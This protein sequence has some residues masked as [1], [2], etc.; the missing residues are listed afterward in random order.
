M[1]RQPQGSRFDRGM[2]ASSRHTL[3]QYRKPGSR[4]VGDRA[5]DV[6]SLSKEPRYQASTREAVGPHA[7]GSLAGQDRTWPRPRRSVDSH[8]VQTEIKH[9]NRPSSSA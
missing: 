7:S 5:R 6:V 9:K 3:R 8:S 2:T 4:W 1:V